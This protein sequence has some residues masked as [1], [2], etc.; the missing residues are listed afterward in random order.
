MVT[1][2]MA[3][4]MV[5]VVMTV[6]MAVVVT[7]LMPMA[8]AVVVV[9]VLMAVVMVS[10]VMTVPMAATVVGG[11]HLV[12]FEQSNAEQQGQRHLSFHRPQDPRIVLDGS[13]L[14]LDSLKPLLG[15]CLLYTSPSPRDRG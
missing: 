2:L 4:V 7:V 3:V 6:P 10:V 5:S 12:G 13:E 14:L 8:V 1:V 9:L 11:T 15:D